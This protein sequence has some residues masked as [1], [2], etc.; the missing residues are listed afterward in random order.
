LLRVP[1]S[2]RRPVVARR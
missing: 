1:T 2:R